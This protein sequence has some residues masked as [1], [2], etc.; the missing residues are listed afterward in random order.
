M[1]TRLKSDHSRC[2][3]T[4]EHGKKRSTLTNVFCFLIG[5]ERHVVFFV[6]IVVVFS[7]NHKALQYKS[8]VCVGD[9]NENRFMVIVKAHMVKC[10][11]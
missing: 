4:T 10:R 11:V 2:V 5:C 9:S 6:V 1:G 8:I 3:K 7:T